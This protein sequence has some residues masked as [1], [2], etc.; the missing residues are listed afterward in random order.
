VV[1]QVNVPAA[2]RSPSHENGLE[3]PCLTLCSW[4]EVVQ[5]IARKHGDRQ[6]VL[7]IWAGFAD[8]PKAA[9]GDGKLPDSD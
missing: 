3:L 7:D 9:N 1:R 2:C 6:K 8:Y 5:L 4:A